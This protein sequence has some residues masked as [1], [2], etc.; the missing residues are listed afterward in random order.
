MQ[1]ALAQRP[2]A[3]PL[4][5]SGGRH[6]IAGNPRPGGF[7]PVVDGHILPHH[8]F[9]PQ[10]PAISKN[11]PLL[12]GYNRDET[13]F[14]FMQ[15][16][17]TGV[18]QLSEDSLRRRLEQELGAHAEA[19]YETYRKSRPEASPTDLF[20]AITTARMF[21]AGT[22][23]IAERK[24]AQGGAPVYMYLFTHETSALVPGTQH[25]V[26]AAHAAEI[27]YKFF[28]QAAQ[29]GSPAAG[30]ADLQEPESIATA[31]NMSQMWAAFAR[32]GRPAAKGQPQWPPYTLARR[33]TMEINAQCRV[34]YD[35]WREERLLWEKLDTPRGTA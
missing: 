33:A 6:G 15:Q 34:L 11:K 12:T 24:A 28:L 32:T 20:I 29:S 16:K 13:I 17:D 8:P 4:T 26:G 2:D 9:D 27:P 19:V 31:R 3:G 10:A 30:R 14:F 25:K 7:G 22:I 23:T 21:G 35:P 18:F 5:R 1:A